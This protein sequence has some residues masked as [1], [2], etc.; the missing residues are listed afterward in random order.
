MIDVFIDLLTQTFNLMELAVVAVLLA[1]AIGNI[2]IA[3][4]I[5]I[6][7]AV[8]NAVHYVTGVTA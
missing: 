5:G 7:L 3:V 2:L 4:T 8:K 6:G 1:G